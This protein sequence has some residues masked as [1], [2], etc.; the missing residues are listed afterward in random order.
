M[1]KR[2]ANIRTCLT[3]PNLQPLHPIVRHQVYVVATEPPTL[4]E[5]WPFSLRPQRA[6][7]DPELTSY[8]LEFETRNLSLCYSVEEEALVDVN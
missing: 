7:S 8:R 2:N 1:L 6:F 5:D 3:V 4:H